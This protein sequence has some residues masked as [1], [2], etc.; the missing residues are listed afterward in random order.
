[1][2]IGRQMQRERK[3][4]KTEE[5]IRKRT[6]RQKIGSETAEGEKMRGQKATERFF[7]CSH[8]SFLFP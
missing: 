6:D 8:I 7:H 5:A 2:Q 1:M 4:S 3:D